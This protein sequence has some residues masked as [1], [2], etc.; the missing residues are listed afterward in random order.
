ME[1]PRSGMASRVSMSEPKTELSQLRDVAKHMRHIRSA[2][3]R[4]DW[5]SDDSSPLGNGRTRSASTLTQRVV[6]FSG[7][8]DDLMRAC[9]DAQPGTVLDMGGAT[10]TAATMVRSCSSRGVLLLSAC[11]SSPVTSSLG[12]DAARRP[13]RLLPRAPPGCPTAP[14][15]RTRS[16]GRPQRNH[17]PCSSAVRVRAGEPCEWHARWVLSAKLEL[18]ASRRPVGQSARTVSSRLCGCVRAC[19]GAQVACRARCSTSTWARWTWYK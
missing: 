7:D 13:L 1:D 3:L 18:A 6:D 17:V 10:I 4:G 19:L 8:F 14:R 11:L 12:R 16:C 9:A 5:E 2:S 15:L